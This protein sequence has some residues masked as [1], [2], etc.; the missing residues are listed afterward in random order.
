MIGPILTYV[1]GA[2]VVDV[3][4]RPELAMRRARQAADARG[5]PLLNVGAGVGYRGPKNLLLGP[6]LRGDVNVDITA[7]EFWTPADGYGPEVYKADILCLP[8]S[9]R[10]FGAAVA[11]HVLEH[12]TNPEKAL[13]EL[14][15]VADEV[16]V[17]CPRWWGFH[18]WAQPDHKWY[19][20]RDGTFER[21]GPRRDRHGRPLSR[22]PPGAQ[23]VLSSR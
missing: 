2:Y 8:F 17:V 1:V 20:R 11:C 5:K 10:R 3:I 22:V 23:A 7:D 14:Y 16:F 6:E 18:T 21:M 4:L 19:L 12:V 15:R 9:G 13:R